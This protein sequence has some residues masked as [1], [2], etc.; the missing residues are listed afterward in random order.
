MK[1]DYTIKFYSCSLMEDLDLFSIYIIAHLKNYYSN[2]KK[3]YIRL[4]AI[5]NAKKYEKLPYIL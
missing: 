1:E 5:I 4:Y 2:L 3:I